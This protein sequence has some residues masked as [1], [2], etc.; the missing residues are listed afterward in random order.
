M[1]YTKERKLKMWNKGDDYKNLINTKRWRGL[2]KIQLSNHPLCADCYQVGIIEPACEVH[3][4]IPVESV[5]NREERK[6]LMFDINNLVSLCH[7]CHKRRHV[8]LHSHKK[9]ENIR[10]N[11][12][13]TEWF[14]KKFF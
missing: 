2:R 1:L 14:R 11:K 5:S 7:E 3:H 4:V 8:N 9:E 10:R 12:E 6:R 13:S